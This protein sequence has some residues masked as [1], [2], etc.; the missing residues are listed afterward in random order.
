MQRCLQLAALGMGKTAP[1]PMVGAV[2][3]FENRIIGEGWHQN[4][5][6]P[7]AE[8]NCINSVKDSDKHLISKSTLY[9]S[10]EPCAHYGKTP[11]CAQLVIDHK[12]PNVVIGC[13]D[14]FAQVN[15]KGIQMLKD[16]GIEVAYSGFEAE[17]LHLNRVFF[18]NHRLQR[19]YIILKWAETNNG[20]IAPINT[21]NFAIS[22]QQ[23]QLLVH[24]WRAWYSAILVG[25]NTVVLDNPQLNNRFWADGRQPVRVILD[26]K[27]ELPC[28]RNVFD[29]SQI[30][31]IYNQ[32]FSLESEMT[33]WIKVDADDFINNILK[34]LYLKGI[35]SILVEGGTKTLNTFI[36]HKLY[37][38]IIQIK[39]ERIIDD[40]IPAPTVPS[41]VQI[42]QQIVGSDT[43][44]Y[45][46]F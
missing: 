39:S 20:F 38:N 29:G 22:N 6:G 23:T 14:I 15:G 17:C 30:T 24:Q 34:D 43:I 41:C 21:G 36:D 26:P 18:T 31:Y 19:P 27:N 3:V 5:G 4:Y 16:A 37:D 9:V 11:P 28:D 1:N 44:N 8:V 40:G 33:N 2:L 10:L 12:I 45:F 7:H 32:H 35:T 13:T 42:E 46:Y 25:Y